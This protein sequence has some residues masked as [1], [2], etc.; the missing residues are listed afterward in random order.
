MVQAIYGSKK[1]INYTLLERSKNQNKKTKEFKRLLEWED[2]PDVLERDK[3]PSEMIIALKKND[4][5]S[6]LLVELYGGD[7]NFYNSK[8][9]NILKAYYSKIE[10]K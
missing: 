3:K 9:M 5:F 1:V 10:K 7:F 6:S 2:Y 4:P 8:I